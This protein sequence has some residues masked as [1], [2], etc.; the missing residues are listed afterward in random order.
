VR[1][2]LTEADGFTN[3]QTDIPNTTC[4]FDY[5]KSEADLTAKLDE[6]AKTNSHIRDWKKKE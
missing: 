5:A 6:L 3:V 4:R 2:A 1:G